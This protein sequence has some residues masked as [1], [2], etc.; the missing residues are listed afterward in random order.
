MSD[1]SCLDSQSTVFET[2]YSLLRDASVKRRST[3]LKYLA[4]MSA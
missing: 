1:A 2:D 4:I 3:W